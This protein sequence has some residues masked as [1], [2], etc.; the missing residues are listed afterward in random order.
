MIKKLISMLI[1]VLFCATFCANVFAEGQK[2]GLI[3]F[4]KAG[5]EC[6]K[7][8]AFQAEFEGK[9]KKAKEE[10]DKMA[11]ELRKLRDESDLLS[12]KA[13]AKKEE[14]L[15]KK[16]VAFNDSRRK[17]SE[18][19]IRWRD[20]Q[21]REITKEITDATAAYAKNNGYDMIL[22]QMVAVYFTETYD[23]TD[24]ILKELNK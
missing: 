21:M 14:E 1:L 13:K 10:L 7:G 8:K 11:K 15:R 4:R 9:D 2:V 17:K 16:Q 12:D 20:D 22:D 19:I 6:K 3:N 18:E 5:F 23:I 24:E